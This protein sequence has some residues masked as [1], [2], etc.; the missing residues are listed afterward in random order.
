MR[1]FE[2]IHPEKIEDALAAAGDGDAAFLGGGTN[3]VD[4]MNL[5]IEGPARLIDIGAL[6]LDRIEDAGGGLSIGAAVTNAD[7]AAHPAIRERYPMAS[8]A[9]LSGASPQIRNKA[10]TAGNLLQRTRCAY[11]YDR[12]RRCNKRAPGSGCD[13]IEGRDRTHAILGADPSCIATHPSDLA[14]A[15]VALNAVAVTARRDGEG[16]DLPVVDLLRLPGDHPERDHVLEPGELIVRIDL[17]ADPPAHQAFRKVRER[18]SFEFAAAS[19]GVACDE[20]GGR[21][22]NVRVA[23]GGVAHKPW[24]AGAAEV[25]LEGAVPDVPTIGKA[26]AAALADAMPG[27]DAA[28][29]RLTERLIFATLRD[30]TAGVVAKGEAA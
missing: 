13:A 28:K 15:L 11:F 10:T 6:G 2:Y 24:R 7:L 18:A 4:L 27:A 20:A 14:V 25:L 19:I 3:L 23:L 21:L 8:A 29:I 16:R 1:P 26:A 22:H 17:P 12:A 30:L 5:E 9:V